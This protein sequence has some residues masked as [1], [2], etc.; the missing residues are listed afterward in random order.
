[1]KAAPSASDWSNAYQ[2]HKTRQAIEERPMKPPEGMNTSRIR[3]KSPRT[4][5]TDGQKMTLTMTPS[6]GRDFRPFRYIRSVGKV[7]RS[8]VQCNR[9]RLPIANRIRV[10][11]NSSGQAWKSRSRVLRRNPA[12]PRV[13]A[14]SQGGPQCPGVVDRGREISAWF[15]RSECNSC[16]PERIRGRAGPASIGTADQTRLRVGGT[17]SC[18]FRTATR[19]FEVS[20]VLVDGPVDLVRYHILQCLKAHLAQSCPAT[21]ARYHSVRLLHDGFSIMIRR[22]P[23]RLHRPRGRQS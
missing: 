11:A 7:A 12:R 15:R 13:S 19:G 4:R 18:M 5:K 2:R 16:S 17:G 20:M 1:M 21:R 23:G 10:D 22:R 8:P 14:R 9:S 3:S 6:Q